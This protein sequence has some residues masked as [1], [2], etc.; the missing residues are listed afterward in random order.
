M[1]WQC[2]A[3]RMCK[4]VTIIFRN[5]IWRETDSNVCYNGEELSKC[6][7]YPH[8]NVKLSRYYRY[9]CMYSI[10]CKCTRILFIFA[11]RLVMRMLPV[12]VHNGLYCFILTEH[13][14]NLSEIGNLKWMMGCFSRTNLHIYIF[15][16]I[17]TKLY[18]IYAYILIAKPNNGKAKRE[19]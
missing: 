14:W 17:H 13:E 7:M 10:S 2:N 1:G 19:W 11:F 16:S 3:L 15:Y 6:L 8:V 4:V 12:D 5:D 18:I 9:V